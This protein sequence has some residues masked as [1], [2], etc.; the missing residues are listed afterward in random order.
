MK[1]SENTTWAVFFALGGTSVVRFLP[2]H[3]DVPHQTK[4]KMF[5]LSRTNTDLHISHS[6]L[7][8]IATQIS[9]L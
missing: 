7:G 1:I 8:S 2:L 4:G 6:C 9:L 3:S 5:S